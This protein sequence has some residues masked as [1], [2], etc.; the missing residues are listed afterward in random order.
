[1]EVDSMYSSL[2]DYFRGHRYTRYY[3][4]DTSEKVLDNIQNSSRYYSFGFERAL[5]SNTD[6]LYVKAV[7]PISP[8]ARAGLKKYDK[9]L[10][11]NDVSITGNTASLYQK[12]DS[13][14]AASTTFKVLRGEDILTLPAMRKE[15]VPEPTVYLDSLNGIPLIT[16][17]EFTI[18]TNDPEG[19]RAEF[20]KIL[21]QIRS[22]KTAIIDVRSNP[23]GNIEHCTA[24]A[25]EL[26]PRLNSK[27]VYDVQ[28]YHDEK[29]GNVVD[30]V[31][32]FARDFLKS[33]GDGAS[34]KW[35]IIQNQWSA[36][37]AERFAAA[38]KASR[39]ETVIIGQSSY[40]KGIGQTYGKT[41]L[42][43][44]AYIT[45]IQTYYPDGRT[46]HDVGVAPDVQTPEGD[47]DALRYAAIE[48][49]QNFD[50]GI[51]AKRLP[52]Q[53]QP[54]TL[55]PEHLPR[56]TDLG[57]YKVVDLFTIAP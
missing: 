56:K 10:F 45:C 13:L 53:L 11:A 22:A 51:L 23:G 12:T 9:L 5:I 32:Y 29:R 24:M 14:F 35:I 43:G 49:A 31:I 54:E 3:P 57:A 28:H 41:Y 46:F 18:R 26:A 33:V 8:A 21:Q 50:S 16:I 15:E 34:I 17:T 19:T 37:C 40:G 4:P 30:T 27:L 2:K 7:Y 42:G 39:P 1:M 48:A 25:A 38:V 55:P 52:I 20:K 44:L 47:R 6:T 36:S